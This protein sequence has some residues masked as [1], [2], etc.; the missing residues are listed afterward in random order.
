MH[1]L[2]ML[3]DANDTALVFFIKVGNL[4][5]SPER[6]KKRKRFFYYCFKHI[7]V[8]IN[9]FASDQNHVGIV[10][11]GQIVYGDFGISAGIADQVARP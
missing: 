4:Q 9:A 5:T 1:V 7:P 2:Y 6:I 11:A 8:L 3:R 10:D